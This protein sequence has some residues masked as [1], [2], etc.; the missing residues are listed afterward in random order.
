MATFIGSGAIRSAYGLFIGG[1]ME[2]AGAV[3]LGYTVSS[4][5]R[6]GIAPLDTPDC[7]ACGYCHSKMS[8][9]IAAMC[10]TLVGAT[11]LVMLATF[12]GMLI[13]TTHSVIGGT[14]FLTYLGGCDHTIRLPQHPPQVPAVPP[15]PPP[16]GAASTG[17]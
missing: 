12:L 8:W 16:R 17:Q 5:V 9:Y 11:S 14:F 13:S 6:R 7:W 15:L 3:L 4:T 2:W 10:A 1:I